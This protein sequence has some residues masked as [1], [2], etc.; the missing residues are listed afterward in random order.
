MFPFYQ[1]ML[2]FITYQLHGKQLV[3]Q[4]GYMAE[5]SYLDGK[6]LLTVKEFGDCLPRV[7]SC[8]HFEDI[9][10]TDDVYKRFL[11]RLTELAAKSGCSSLLRIH[12]VGK[13]QMPLNHFEALFFRQWSF[14]GI[15]HEESPFSGEQTSDNTDIHRMGIHA[16]GFVT[17][18][19]PMAF[20]EQL[21][22]KQRFH[23]A[24]HDFLIIRCSG[25]LQQFKQFFT[26]VI[27]ARHMPVRT[28]LL[29]KKRDGLLGL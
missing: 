14:I 9:V 5:V 13:E 8:W 7:H 11:L 28:F 4:D 18:D 3:K 12:R 24:F 2:P 20:A 25:C 23:P 15:L 10:G 21:C 22:K 16:S 17:V 26:D 6:T 1:P 27:F 29:P 19:V